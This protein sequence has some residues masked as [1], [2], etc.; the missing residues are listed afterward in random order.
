MKTPTPASHAATVEAPP[1]FA[2]RLDAEARFDAEET[3]TVDPLP[4]PRPPP[5]PPPRSSRAGGAAPPP[6]HAAP[7]SSTDATVLD[8]SVL[9]PFPISPFG[10]QV[11]APVAAPAPFA[12]PAPAPFAAP[13]PVP[14]PA[15]FAAPMPVPAPFA[16]PPPTVAAPS[17][18]LGSPHVPNPDATAFQAPMSA[19]VPRII[20]VDSTAPMS[21][22]PAVALTPPP[23]TR[24][25]PEGAPAIP[26]AAVG[27]AVVASAPSAPSA[28]RSRFAELDPSRRKLQLQFVVAVVGAVTVSMLVD[29]LLGTGPFFRTI[30]SLFAV[31]M[32]ALWLLVVA[33]S[34]EPDADGSWSLGKHGFGNVLAPW[35]RIAAD[36]ARSK[37]LDA[38]ARRALV[39]ATMTAIGAPLT[40]G[41]ELL[42][43]VELALYGFLGV[44]SG[45]AFVLDLLAAI[46][47]S[48]A[49]AGLLIARRPAASA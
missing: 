16:A 26:N 38:G 39:G 48:V 41:F 14:V 36:R 44:G 5:P 7:P 2:A 22:P 3:L 25:G 13:L 31:S 30:A 37:E 12:A 20:D 28:M 11:P 27:G 8:P 46:T 15:P 19:A 10:A 17:V 18:T 4:R 35:R 1:Q 49:L 23:A 29:A 47:A 34:A 43:F 33:A 24:V 40:V 45:S 6:P 42:R 9:G 32:A 21:R